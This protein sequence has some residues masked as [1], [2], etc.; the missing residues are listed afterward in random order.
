VSDRSR[1]LAVARGDE[2]PDLVVEGAR[3]FSAFTKEWLDVQVAIAD[4]RI[5]GLAESY[6]GGERLDGRG[7]FLVPGFI[8]AHVH[9]ESSL[10]TVDQFARA[11]L[12]HGTTAIVSDPHEI[13][14]VLGSDGVHWMLDVAA[15]VPLEMF[16]M[17]SSCVPASGFESPR[18]MLTPGDMEGILRRSH[19]LGVA[20]M[21]NFP[22]VIAGD[23]AELAKLR[24]RGATHADG[25][26]PG[27]RGAA[28]DAYVAAGI[29]SDHEATTVEE[30]LEKRRKGMWV[31]LR[32]ASGA[33]NL[34]ALLPL[35]RA[36]GPEH[37][38]FC[39]DDREP[40]VL[41][42][43]GHLDQMCRVAVAEGVAP[44]DALLLA[45][46]HPARAHGLP[47]LGAIAPGYGADLV[48]LEDL[49]DFRPVV[50]LKDGEVVVRDGVVRPF[51]VPEIPLWV[52]QTVHS[53]PLAAPDLA[54]PAEG[55]GEVRVIEI[56][57][58][59]LV[60]V[61]RVELPTVRDGLVVAD[62]ARDIAKIAV[63]ERHHATGRI[64]RGLV[65][66]F[67]LRA[68]AFAS[69]VA[70]D[71]HNIVVVGMDDDDMARCV[72][73][74]QALGGGLVVAAGGE[75][76]GELALPV[77]GL[78]SDQPVEAVV[79]RAEALRTLLSELGVGLESPFM[80]LS[81]L[82]LSVI[83]ALKLTDRGLVDVE[84]FALVPLE[85]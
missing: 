28:L 77:A 52:R 32:E 16:V 66:G 34:R 41:V 45:T 78:L 14:N 19:A 57:P 63:V 12:P 7:R 71:A 6:A 20:E 68:G 73:R 79:Q 33:R 74:L 5:A 15:H 60:T 72:A 30:A 23:P 8:D 62:P 51:T 17:A 39:T 1:L 36:Y 55:D 29:R 54:M 38:A 83:P 3:V 47:E 67:G 31:L 40:E 9:V 76:R 59:Q 65:R 49:V 84:R 80:T 43:E 46:L 56:V 82:A 61:A 27:V 2:P 48:L 35:I 11:V 22:G 13:A 24:V 50:V 85:A 4:G 70:H 42:R 58:D 37:C 21:M 44:E 10:L 53:A 81:F 25:H 18:R 75:V 64:G 26:A 69:T